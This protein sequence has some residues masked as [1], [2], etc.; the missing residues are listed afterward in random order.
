[1]KRKGVVKDLL[2]RSKMAYDIARNLK[3]KNKDKQ[4]GEEELITWL[5]HL[6]S[7]DKGVKNDLMENIKIPVFWALYKIG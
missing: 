3:K 7:N 4:K 1:M 2:Y 5:E 6:Y